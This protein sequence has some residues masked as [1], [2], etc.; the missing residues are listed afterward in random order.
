MFSSLFEVVITSSVM[1]FLFLGVVSIVV[2]QFNKK[3]GVRLFKKGT[4]VYVRFAKVIAKKIAKW[5][6]RIARYLG[7]QF[8]AFALPQ[9]K[10]IAITVTNLIKNKMSKG[11]N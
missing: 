7:K 8:N 3:E 10:K 1:Y 5:S 9:V 4:A 6:V 2:W 11:E